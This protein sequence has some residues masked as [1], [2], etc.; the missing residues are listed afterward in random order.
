MVVPKRRIANFNFVTPSMSTKHT[1]ERPANLA[2]N[3]PW[4]RPPSCPSVR[5]PRSASPSPMDSSPPSKVNYAEYFLAQND[6]DIEGDNIPNLANQRSW[7][8]QADN[9]APF[10][11]GN[12]PFDQNEANT[13]YPAA[14]PTGANFAMIP[15]NLESSAILY[16]ANQ[17]ADPTLWDG[18]FSSISLFGTIKVLED[19]AKNIA[20]SLQRI[21]T[22][23]K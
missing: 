14:P 1:N 7:A 10:P 9:R 19:N 22:F 21:A 20:C 23:I 15:I 3:L 8:D 6:M 18:T 12:T 16:Q 13:P 11:Q 17:S 4:S 5:G 2:D